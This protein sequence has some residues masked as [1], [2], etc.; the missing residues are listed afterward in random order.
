MKLTN[1]IVYSSFFFFIRFFFT[2][3]ISDTTDDTMVEWRVMKWGEVGENDENLLSR[4]VAKSN[5]LLMKKSRS[6]T[7]HWF[8]KALR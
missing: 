7:C 3:E 4:P 8:K 1:S 2:I 6:A 5:G